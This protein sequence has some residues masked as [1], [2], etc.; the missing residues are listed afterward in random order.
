LKDREDGAEP[1]RE[2]LHLA[3]QKE[4]TEKVLAAGP[5]KHTV[6]PDEIARYLTPWRLKK[7][8]SKLL[9]ADKGITWASSVLVLCA[10]E[11]N[12]GSVLADMGFLNVTVSDLSE[13][14]CGVAMRRDPRL[15]AQALNA[16]E[17]GLPALSFDIVV[18]QDGLHHLQRPV[19]GFTEM[20]RRS[21]S[22]NLM[23]P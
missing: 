20:L 10:A 14:I 7:A 3:R 18:V 19:Q 1:S 4:W 13:T 12:E 11:G 17:S 16:E 6:A 8:V 5:R 9:G 22:W 2:E 23:T 21:Y 15:K